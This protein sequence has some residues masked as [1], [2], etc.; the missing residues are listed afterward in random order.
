MSQITELESQLQ[1]ALERLRSALAARDAAALPHPDEQALLERIAA[2]ESE[3]AELRGRAG[4][5]AGQ[6]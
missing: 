3:K 4:A 5:A 1:E 2:L 6:A